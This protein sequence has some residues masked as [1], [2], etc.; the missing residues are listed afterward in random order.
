MG[1][2]V[3]YYVTC[4]FCGEDTGRSDLTSDDAWAYAERGG[5][6]VNPSRVA[7]LCEECYDE[8]Q[9]YHVQS[10]N[11]FCVLCQSGEHTAIII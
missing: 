11:V 10:S 2:H 1:L 5:W 6:W 7:A 9:T 8:N 4:N 3:S